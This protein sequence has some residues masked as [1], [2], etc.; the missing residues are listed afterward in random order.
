MGQCYI[1]NRGANKPLIIEYNTVISHVDEWP[2][3]NPDSSTTYRQE[4]VEVGLNITPT[5]LLA[6]PT[7][8]FYSIHPRGTMKDAT[9]VNG[10]YKF[11]G[12]TDSS[13]IFGPQI[14]YYVGAIIPN[15][16]PNNDGWIDTPV[17]YG[18]ILVGTIILGTPA[19]EVT[20]ASPNLPFRPRYVLYGQNGSNDKGTIAYWNGQL[21]VS[22]ASARLTC[23]ENS[24]TLTGKGAGKIIAWG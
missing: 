24:I 14:Y 7:H 17:V 13:T 18:N 6:L 19:G 9:F 22:D 10:K 23:N 2:D 20:W 21:K 16:T 15:V 4:T 8:T 12:S 11:T 3:S 1:R 5:I